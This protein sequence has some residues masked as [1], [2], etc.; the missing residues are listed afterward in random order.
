[1]YF[2][3]AVHMASADS[4][5]GEGRC[6]LFSPTVEESPGCILGL[7]WRPHYW[8]AVVGDE[9]GVCVGDWGALLQ[10]DEEV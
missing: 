4:Q 1:M 5:Q 3:H 8:W 7:F 10:P 9:H 2:I 6:S